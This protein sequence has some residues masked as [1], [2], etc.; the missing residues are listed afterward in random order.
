MFRAGPYSY[1]MQGGS[2]KF[3]EA[4]DIEE[5]LRTFVEQW[6]KQ[7]GLYIEHMVK[8]FT[9]L[10]EQSDELRIEINKEER[11]IQWAVD[12]LKAEYGTDS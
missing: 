8:E 4:R 10:F 1:V 11:E 7:L 6:M 9:V 2:P 3:Q 12:D 5:R